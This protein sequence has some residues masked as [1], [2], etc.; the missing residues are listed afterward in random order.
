MADP[1]H[2]FISYRH[3]EP[4]SN[5]AHTFAKAL[6]KAGN[7]VFIDTGIRWGKNW[8]KK[9]REALEKTDYLLVLL[10]RETA[11]SEMVVRE[12]IG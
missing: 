6:K 7:D 5:L 9:I 11:N 8:V 10:S 3:Q 1:F 2:I 4:D 12:V